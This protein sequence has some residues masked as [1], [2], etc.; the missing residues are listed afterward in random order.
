MIQGKPITMQKA[1]EDSISL[2]SRITPEEYAD[3]YAE[4]CH[5][6]VT[7]VLGSMDEKGKE[8]Y[9]NGQCSIYNLKYN[10]ST[11]EHFFRHYIDLLDMTQDQYVGMMNHVDNIPN[12][13]FG[14]YGKFL[15]LEAELIRKTLESPEL[16]KKCYDAFMEFITAMVWASSERKDD[17][18]AIVLKAEAADPVK[19]VE[20]EIDLTRYRTEFQKD[21]HDGTSDWYKALVDRI[22]AAYEAFSKETGHKS[23]EEL[24]GIWNL[25]DSTLKDFLLSDFAVINY[26]NMSSITRRYANA[27]RKNREKAFEDPELLKRYCDAWRESIISAHDLACKGSGTNDA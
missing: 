22:N 17:V 5:I 9:A 14:L 15:D 20:N 27:I 7:D 13:N 12:K 21:R 26:E 11:N 4:E 2:F 25:D 10:A 19:W 18:L 1:L 6:V 23:L 24:G 16:Q 3:Y 8:S